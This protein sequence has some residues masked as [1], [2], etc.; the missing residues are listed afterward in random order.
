MEHLGFR[1][2]SLGYMFDLDVSLGLPETISSSGNPA[3]N[4]SRFFITLGKVK[5][6]EI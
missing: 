3:E 1:N 5:I 6:I 2:Q 4:I